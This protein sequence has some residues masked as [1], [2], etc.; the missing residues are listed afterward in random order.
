[1]DGDPARRACA[2]LAGLVDGWCRCRSWP[3]LGGSGFAGL[4][5]DEYFGS[6]GFGLGGVGE[7]DLQ[8]ALL[9]LATD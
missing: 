4:G 9:A 5:F 1:M 8:E 7:R 6:F 2:E 3:W